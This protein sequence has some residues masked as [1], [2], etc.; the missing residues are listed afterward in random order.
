[1]TE[2]PDPPIPVGMFFIFSSSSFLRLYLSDHFPV[3][4]IGNHHIDHIRRQLRP[5]NSSHAKQV[6]HQKQNRYIQADLTNHGQIKRY[7]APVNSLHKMYHVEAQKH[8]RRCKTAGLQKLCSEPY[9]IRIVDKCSHDIRR[10]DPVKNH[11]D[12]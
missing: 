9:R 11:A 12:N 5:H 4:D 2:M 6:I 7:F 8:E 1:M 10:T 3:Y